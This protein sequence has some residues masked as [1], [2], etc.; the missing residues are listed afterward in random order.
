MSLVSPKSPP[1]AFHKMS[2][3][4]TLEPLEALKQC[5]EAF[6]RKAE[7][8]KSVWEPGSRKIA[9][10]YV[11]WTCVPCCL[12]NPWNGNFE[13][14]K[15]WFGVKKIDDVDLNFT[16]SLFFRGRCGRDL[17]GGEPSVFI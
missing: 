13:A 7:L 11:L 15:S 4:P 10:G 14:Q 17:C 5:Q 1:N 2:I 6:A 8:L 9:S 3:L 16:V 12:E